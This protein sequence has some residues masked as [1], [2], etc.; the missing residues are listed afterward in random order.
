MSQAPSPS[1]KIATRGSKLALWQSEYIASLLKP[2]GVDVAFEIIKTTGDKVQDRFLHEI[3]GKGLFVKE[4]EESLARGDT[5]FAMH[6]LKDMPAKIHPD[7][8]L[9]AVLKRH[10]ATDALIV[11]HDLDKQLPET[12]TISFHCLKD[13]G[14]INVGTAS[15]R[16]E[17]LL[18]A[19]TPNLKCSGLRGNVD[20]RIKKLYE[21]QYDA[22][23]LA[24]AS[25]DRLD[26][27]AQVK[28]RR[29][30]PSWFLPSAAQGALAI[31]TFATS[32]WTK[33]LEVLQCHTTRKCVDIERALL[34]KL[35]GDC[36]MPFACQVAITDDSVDIR[37]E[38]Y[39]H[40]GESART[41]LSE[42]IANIDRILDQAFDDLVNNGAKKI[43][44]DLK[45]QIPGL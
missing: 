36:T 14:D 38:I 22:I 11:S 42:P 27:K 43:C 18:K 33:F 8:A 21:G 28:W 17:C 10:A 37:A 29:L 41:N 20:T 3:G 7:F 25:L 6:S 34:A 35:G 12:E 39:N 9:A 16:R 24:E 1:A 26:L 31:E 45:I 15:L 44:E 13:L 4:L 19:Y 23:I 32:P 30:D 5:Q 40:N 2:H